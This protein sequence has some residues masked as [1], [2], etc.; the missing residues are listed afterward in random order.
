MMYRVC[1][2]PTCHAAGAPQPAA[3]FRVRRRSICRTCINRRAAELDAKR[4]QS[5]YAVDRESAG[6]LAIDPFRAWLWDRML[7]MRA[8]YD[9][10]YETM[11]MR[12]GVTA[13][14]LSRWLNDPEARSVNLD[15]V[16]RCFCRWGDAGLLRQLYPEV[17]EGRRLSLVRAA[18]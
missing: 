4:R 1:S 18:A 11:C 15:S 5:L 13:K 7:E 8:S 14:T 17:Y 3:E 2:S 10:P 16:D 9:D 6:L 12:I